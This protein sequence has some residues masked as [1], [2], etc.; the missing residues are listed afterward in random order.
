MDVTKVKKLIC[1]KPCSHYWRHTVS[2]IEQ[3]SLLCFSYLVIPD[4]I[5]TRANGI[6]VE[7]LQLCSHYWHHTVS[8]IKQ[9]SLLCFSY[10]I[11]YLLSNGIHYTYRSFARYSS[12]RPLRYASP[13]LR[14]VF[15]WTGM[16]YSRTTRA[17]VKLIKVQVSIWSNNP[18]LSVHSWWRLSLNS[19]CC[20]YIDNRTVFINN[21]VWT[22]T[23][24]S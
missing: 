6:Y 1:H 14:Q 11:S 17:R 7:L 18:F 23:I 19:V 5:L 9:N 21:L 4:Q 16:L 8:T 20:F 3:N 2:T 15:T 12:T 22:E 10:L 13:L 24:A